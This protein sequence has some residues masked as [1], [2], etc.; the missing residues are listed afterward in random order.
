MRRLIVRFIAEAYAQI[1]F[2]ISTSQ[3]LSY[4]AASQFKA[5]SRRCSRAGYVA[6]L[7]GI[8]PA[9][10]EYDGMAQACP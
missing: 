9:L 3:L 2:F 1:A 7:A 6:P 8:V 5:C 4:T 10:R